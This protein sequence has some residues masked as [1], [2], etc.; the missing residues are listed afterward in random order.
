MMMTS[1]KITYAEF[2]EDMEKQP[3]VLIGGTTGAGKSVA[4]NGFVC[5][6]LRHFPDEVKLMLIDPKGNELL[7]YKNL[8]HAVGHAVDP[9]EIEDALSWM[10]REMDARFKD[11]SEKG[12]KWTDYPP[13]YIIIDEYMD[14][15][16]NCNKQA[17]KD[18]IK[19]SAKG[20]AAKMHI[21]LCTQRPTSDVIDGRIK[22]NFT[23]TLAL[24]T[25]NSQ[26]SKNLIG[27][28]GCENLPDYGQAYYST[29]SMR[30]NVIVN[31][32]FISDDEIKEIVDHWMNQVK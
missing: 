11:M 13:V 19:I 3:H 15:L 18:L 29:P 12:Q 17:V 6:L 25:R 10:V 2:Y 8:P 31:I 9:E 22:A 4:M 1:P 32:P 30:D 23:T 27:E 21:I 16:F 7:D 28:S 20:R 24:R 14:I 26:E 5:S